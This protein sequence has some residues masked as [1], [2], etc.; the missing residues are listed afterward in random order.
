MVPALCK[1]PIIRERFLSKIATHDN[2]VTVRDLV[3]I[4]KIHKDYP[5]APLLVVHSTNLTFYALRIIEKSRL[6]PANLRNFEA[7]KKLRSSFCHPFLE[8]Q[9]KT[10]EDERY[11]YIISEYC[12]GAELFEFIRDV[13]RA[14]TA[15]EAKFYISCLILAVEYLHSRQ[16][17]MRKLEPNN[18][19]MDSSGYP[20]LCGLEYAKKLSEKTFTTV[21]A[22]HYLAPEVIKRQGYG[23]SVDY[24]SLG[25]LLYEFLYGKVPFGEE[26]TDP[27]EIYNE[28]LTRELTFSQ[29]SGQVVEVLRSLLERQPTRRARGSLSKLKKLPWFKGMDWVS[30]TQ[31]GLLT[32]QCKS[33]YL[34]SEKN[35]KQ[36]IPK[37]LAKGETVKHALNVP[38]T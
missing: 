17:A 20:L 16:I 28:I 21:G 33:P 35:L 4:K 3:V 32:K 27:M 38:P 5:G 9:V 22:P 31:E 1:T 10:V 23:V 15:D 13:G 29:L 18:I 12:N 8:A 37:A 11:A 2:P 30:A 19:L 24:W 7:E 14:L 6:L 36:L 26:E 25:V 34:L